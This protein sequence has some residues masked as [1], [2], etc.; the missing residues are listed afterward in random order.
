MRRLLELVVKIKSAVSI[1][2]IN[3]HAEIEH[4]SEADDYQRGS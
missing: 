4:Y 1:S 3:S 2:A